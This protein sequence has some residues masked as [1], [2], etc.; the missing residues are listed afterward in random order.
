MDNISVISTKNKLDRLLT[1]LKG[2]TEES[3]FLAETSTV[4][5]SEIE[6]SIRQLT[7]AVED[8]LLYLSTVISEEDIERYRES[9]QSKRIEKLNSALGDKDWSNKIGAVSAIRKGIVV[10]VKDLEDRKDFAYLFKELSDTELGLLLRGLAKEVMGFQQS[11]LH[12]VKLERINSFSTFPKT[13]LSTLGP[14]EMGVLL[15]PMR[16]FNTKIAL[17][18]EQ[19]TRLVKLSQE[20]LDSNPDSISEENL[21]ILR[22]DLNDLRE[23]MEREITE[24]TALVRFDQSVDVVPEYFDRI[25]SK[26]ENINDLA[27]DYVDS[28]TYKYNSFKNR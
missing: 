1:E 14:K 28:F 20:N 5:R 12:K 15:K 6:Y 19:N 2:I 26:V 22:K 8:K 7:K 11:E 9:V 4:E 25:N 10:G 18:L 24:L 16:E 13:D 21:T 27:K 17:L 23:R 3:R